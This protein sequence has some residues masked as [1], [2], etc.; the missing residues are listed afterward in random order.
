MGASRRPP[1]TPCWAQQYRVGVGDDNTQVRSACA[2][3][4]GRLSGRPDVA[5]P[6]DQEACA[7]AANPGPRSGSPDARRG[8]QHSRR[9]HGR[10]RPVQPE[11]RRGLGQRGRGR[12]LRPRGKPQRLRNAGLVWCD[13]GPARKHQGRDH[14]L[15]SGRGQPALIHRRLRQ[16]TRHLE[17]VRRMAFSARSAPATSTG[18]RSASPSVA[19][20]SRSTALSVALKPASA[21]KS[22]L[23]A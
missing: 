3:R 9:I 4:H 21:Q 5:A 22:R 17:P 6:Q 15:R 20:G 13:R 16:G 12:R 2:A 14:R 19:P 18:P 11:P 8:V 7:D 23:P 1:P 10:I